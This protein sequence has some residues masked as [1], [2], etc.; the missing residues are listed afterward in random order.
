MQLDE[1]V[2]AVS[3]TAAKNAGTRFMS[4]LL[5]F[6]GKAHPCAPLGDDFDFKKTGVQ[7]SC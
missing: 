6:A 4:F 2:T 1:T 7:V 3:A 5:D